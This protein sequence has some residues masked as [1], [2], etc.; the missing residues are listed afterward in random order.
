MYNIFIITIIGMFSTF[1]ILSTMIFTTMI[2]SFF[3]KKNDNKDIAIAL[4]AI[5]NIK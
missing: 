2:M 4:A 5:K 3:L 1:F